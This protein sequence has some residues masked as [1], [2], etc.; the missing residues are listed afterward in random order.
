MEVGI[1]T[2][3]QIWWAG[4]PGFFQLSHLH[5]RTLVDTLIIQQAAISWL[6]KDAMKVMKVFFKS[7]WLGAVHIEI[8]GNFFIDL[9]RSRK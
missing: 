6:R 4:P 5:S 3:E 8:Y 2:V 9:I 1:E 7:K